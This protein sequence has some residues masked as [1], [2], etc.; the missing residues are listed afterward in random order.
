[1]PQDTPPEIPKDPP[2]SHDLGQSSVSLDHCYLSLSE[3]SK[4]PSSPGS[5]DMDTDLVWRQ[6]EVRETDSHWPGQSRSPAGP[7]L[8]PPHLSMLP[9]RTLRLTSRACSPPVTTGTTRGPLPGGSRPC[10]WPGGRPGRA[11]PAGVPPSPRRAKK[12]LAPPR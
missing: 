8:R 12:P 7:H 3:N 4:V 9:T 1:M 10:P 6:Q 11:G 2:D 5:E